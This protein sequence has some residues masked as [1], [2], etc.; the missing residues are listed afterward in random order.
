MLE[1]MTP[2]PTRCNSILHDILPKMSFIQ[3]K[4]LTKP[5]SHAM[6]PLLYLQF[7]SFMYYETDRFYFIINLY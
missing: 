5:T 7:H 4:K 3:Y 2:P 1:I 6:K